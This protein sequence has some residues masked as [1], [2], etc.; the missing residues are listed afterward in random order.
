MLVHQIIKST[1]MKKIF[2][3]I[4]LFITALSCIY[5]KELLTVPCVVDNAP[6]FSTK[7]A[8]VI[9]SNCF[10][11]HNN[12]FSLGNVKLEGYD[13]IKK[14]AATGKLLGVISHAAGFSQM[15]KGGNKLDDCTINIIK[16]WIETGTPNN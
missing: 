4:T 13:N 8:P 15:P 10:S 16:K 11:C 6:S 5:D 3:L 2:F 9:K 14:V 1:K 7:V 12:S